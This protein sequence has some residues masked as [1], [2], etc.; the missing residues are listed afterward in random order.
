MPRTEGSRPP[1]PNKPVKF[2]HK[3]RFHIRQQGLAASTERNYV[4]WIKRFIKYHQYLHP[5]KMSKQQ[6]EQFLHHLVVVEGV[7]INTQ[8]SALN[9]LAFLFNQYLETPLGKLNITR[10]KR[11]PKLP[12][13]LSHSEALAVINYLHPPSKLVVQLLYGSGLR[14]NE[15]LSIR[16]KD[17]DFDANRLSVVNGKGGKN[18]FIILPSQL[19][20][21]IRFQIEHVKRLHAADLANNGGW[22]M[23]DENEI[24]HN[25]KRLRELA[26]QYLFPANSLSYE[27][28]FKR[29]VRHHLSESSIQRYVKKAVKQCELIKEVTPHTFRHSFA[30]RLLESGTNIRV[31]QELLGHA[32]VSTTEIYTHVLHKHGHAVLSPMD[33]LNRQ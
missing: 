32:D 6:V 33:L 10:A 24:S 2:M 25:N 14:I 26:W 13:V 22:V 3:L 11:R 21:D 5:E 17:L 4:G 12:S 20:D 9:A 1:L 27:I 19:H 31:I 16:L 29:L 15:A 18:R 23:A 30:T 28:R 8:K 7:T